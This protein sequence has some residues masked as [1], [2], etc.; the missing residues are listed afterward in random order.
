MKQGKGNLLLNFEVKN[1]LTS[2]LKKQE[3]KRNTE[4]DIEIETEIDRDRDR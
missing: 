2:C 3:D 1:S 4:I